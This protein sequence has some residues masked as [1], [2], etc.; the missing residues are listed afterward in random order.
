MAETKEKL[1]VGLIGCGGI[2]G[3][4]LPHLSKSDDVELVGFC[5]IIVERAEKHVAK[6]GGK[7]YD[8]A[9]KMLEEAKLDAAYIL[10]PTYAHGAPERSCIAANIPFLVEKPLGLNPDDLRS[11]S[12]EVEKSGL[13][14]VAGFMNRYRKSVSRAKDILEED[15]AILLDGA[16]ISGPPVDKDGDYF[17]RNPIGQWWP[18]KE[19][20]G[21]QFV[22][23]VIHTVDIARYLAGEVVEVFAFAATGFNKKNPILV[24]NYTNDDAMVVSMKFANGAIGNIMASCSTAKGGG[25]FLNVWSANHCTKF[26]EWAHH[27]HITKTDDPGHEYIIKGDIDDIFPTEDR[28]FLNAVKTGDR[29]KIKSTHTDGARTTQVCLAANESLV[30][31][32]PV[33]VK[34][35]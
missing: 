8:H 27:A 26:T 32:Q 22:E 13:L 12:K 16:W 14:T 28:V 10:I 33:T 31:G 18:V 20:S 15:P 21:G 7:A 23:Q 11:L 2:S 17:A 29:S 34:Y 3:A 25:V 6:Y 24:P 19:K 35:D 30:T 9:D 4:H 5:D 1:R